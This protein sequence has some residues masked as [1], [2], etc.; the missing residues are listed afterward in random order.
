LELQQQ[1]EGIAM[2]LFSAF[3]AAELLERDRQ[4]IVRALRNTPPDGR[5]GGHP[6]WKMSTIISAMERHGRASGGGIGD[7]SNRPESVQFAQ[8]CEAMKV[9]PTLAQRRAAAIETIPLLID[10][11]KAT[12]A[13]GVDM[14]E[15]SETTA[16]RGDLLCQTGLEGLAVACEWRDGEAWQHF[17]TADVD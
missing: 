1:H 14:G 15:N 2:K 3:A 9:L 6:R 5:D 17:N 13:R 11:I 12:R 4:T 8:A 16:V 10:A 7:G